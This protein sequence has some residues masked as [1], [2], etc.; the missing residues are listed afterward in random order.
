MRFAWYGYKSTDAVFLSFIL[1]IPSACCSSQ[2][3]AALV[4]AVF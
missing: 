4:L 1:S 2:F 3:F